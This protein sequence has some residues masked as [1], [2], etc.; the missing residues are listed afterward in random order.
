MN[1][2]I[3][4]SLFKMFIMHSSGTVLLTT[5][6]CASVGS[7]SAKASMASLKLSLLSKLW[8]V[9]PRCFQFLHKALGKLWSSYTE[10]VRYLL[11]PRV[12]LLNS[13]F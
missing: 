2:F 12:K 13:R 1:D 5:I 11:V 8:R 6:S 7:L 9:E 3:S 10:P 4:D